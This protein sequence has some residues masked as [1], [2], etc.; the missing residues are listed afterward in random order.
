MKVFRISA[1]LLALV[2]LASSAAADMRG[3][4]A[5]EGHPQATI[6]G[7]IT[8]VNVPF[9]GAGPIVT[10]LGGL[11]SFDATGA[12]VRF[13]SGAPATTDSL[14]AGQR[15]L[16]LLDPAAEPLRATTVVIRSDRADVTFTGAVEAVDTAAGTL[17]ILGFTVAVTGRTAF[18]G[19]WD[20][21]DEKG[22]EDVEVGDLALVDAQDVEGGLVATKVMKLSGS[23]TPMKRV[24]GVVDSIGTDSWT[25]AHPDDSTTVVKVDS[26]TKIVGDP[27][28][29]DTVEVLAR[30]QPDGSLLAV[31][32]AGFVPPPVLPTERYTGVVKEI[33]ATSW[34][35]GPKVGDGPDRVFAVNERTR[36]LGSPAVGDEV[37]VL[38][39]RQADGSHLALL[40]AKAVL[41]PPPLAEVAFDGVVKRVS[42]GYPAGT[43]LVDETKVVVSRTTLVK[44]RPGVGDTVHVEGLRNPDG[45]VLARSIEK[46]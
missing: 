28:V 43:W 16:A 35:L 33:G 17:R 10:L 19:P 42:P 44:G 13:V 9:A 15:I 27:K 14:R 24:H 18:G 25:I 45:V 3:I 30:T 22:L 46:L 29:G 5:S 12:T 40:I 32:I 34:T 6:E 39:Q 41:A 4:P 37:G 36:I 31:L 1:L 11:V 20:G 21:A 2:V 7:T 8:S 38:A 26:A 23:V